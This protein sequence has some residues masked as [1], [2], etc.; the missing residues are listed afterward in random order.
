MVRWEYMVEEVNADQPPERYGSFLTLTGFSGWE[1]VSVV[2]VG[3]FQKTVRYT[4][5]FKC[6][7]RKPSQEEEDDEEDEDEL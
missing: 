5:W 2:P 6:P 7:L 4:L 1:L 3:E